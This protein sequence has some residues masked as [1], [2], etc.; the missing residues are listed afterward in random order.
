[1]YQVNNKICS[2][3]GT[4]LAPNEAFCHNCGKPFGALPAP[5]NP[6]PPM[7]D[8]LPEMNNQVPPA[9]QRSS[10]PLKGGVSILVLLILIG[11]FVFL[12]LPRLQSHGNGNPSS[13]KA[14]PTIATLHIT[15]YTYK[16]HTSS[17]WQVAW[18]S[19]GK[20][21]VSAGGLG[22]DSAQVWD[23]VTGKT[24]MTFTSYTVMNTVAWS[25]NGT[26]IACGGNSND[27][28]VI[29]VEGK[30]R[31]A[32][33]KGHQDVVDSVAWSP[34]GKYIA[35]ASYDHTVQIWEAL[36]GTHVLTYKGHSDTVSSVAWSPNGKKLASA[37]LDGTVQV[38]DATTGKTLLTYKGHSDRVYTVA[39]SP[40]GTRIAS[41]GVDETAQVWDATTGK[42]LFTYHG[43]NGSVSSVAWSPDGTRIASASYDK[44][45][46]V[47]N[48]STGGN[49][50]TYTGHHD[51]VF[52]V[53]WSPDGQY[54]ASA[55]ADHTVQIWQSH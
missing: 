46:Q 6:N 14:T 51:F 43:H 18:S 54:I 31:I 28:D 9:P 37:S 36:T 40:N 27:I 48:A 26:Y 44:T 16:G 10:G 7:R 52:S 29:K 22:D 3:C 15:P 20:Q 53:T 34:D 33:Y 23:A 25:P 24:Q 38:W 32:N 19:D 35:S 45:V 49:V 2:A 4:A 5:L 39:W 50:F 8:S 41:G 1:M 12:I 42:T 47:W 17:V 13:Q 21:L 30:Q 55:S 11:G